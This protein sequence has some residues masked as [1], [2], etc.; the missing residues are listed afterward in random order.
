[1]YNLTLCT[2]AC[3]QSYTPHTIHFI[4]RA[5]GS[6]PGQNC[7]MLC[8]LL[9]LC[10]V[11][12]IPLCKILHFAH[13]VYVWNIALCTIRCT[14]LHFVHP[15][16]YNITLC[17]LLITLLCTILHFAHSVCVWNI[18]LCTIYCTI[19][20]VCTILLYN[21]TRGRHL[22]IVFPCCLGTV[23]CTTISAAF[24]IVHCASFSCTMQ[25]QCNT[26]Q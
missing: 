14:I 23:Y 10:T 8:Y 26:L 21:L 18:A 7:S 12:T 11:C 4:L 15:A 17:T 13:S 9:N 6:Y 20:A 24:P 2:L 16:V 19:F 25:Q 1:M 5:R 22:V 3:V